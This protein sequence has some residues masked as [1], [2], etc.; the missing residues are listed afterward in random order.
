MPH[1]LVF[2]LLTVP[3]GVAAGKPTLCLTTSR[4]E[5]TELVLLS[6]LIPLWVCKG[7]MKKKTVNQDQRL[8]G[9]SITRLLAEFFLL[10]SVIATF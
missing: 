1:G 10:Y 6:G 9:N 3:F 5:N 7:A 8:P 2:Y 4:A